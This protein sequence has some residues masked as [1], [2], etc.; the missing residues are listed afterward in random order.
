MKRA[1]MPAAFL[2]ALLSG[3]A[4]A[5]LRGQGAALV[6]DINVSGESGFSASM[7]HDFLTVGSRIFFLA[8]SP[9]QGGFLPQVAATDGTPTGTE[10]LGAPCTDPSCGSKATF[11]AASAASAASATGGTGETLFFT[12]EVDFF[13][14][15][16][17]RSDGTR[18]G[19][20]PLT[21]PGLELD[22]AGDQP[23]AYARVGKQLFFGACAGEQCGLYKSDG[24]VAGTGLVAALGAVPLSL[25]SLGE[26]LFFFA[27]AS[28]GLLALFVSD[29]TAAGTHSLAS[30]PSSLLGGLTAATGRVFFFGGDLGAT[31]GEELWTSDGTAAGT[32]AV[33]SFEAPNP[34]DFAQ[35]FQAV[36]G[37]LYFV[38]DDVTHGPEIWTSDGT[39]AGTRRVTEFGY[40]QPFPNPVQMGALGQRLLFLAT[41]GIHPTQLWSTTGTPESTAPVASI[42]ASG[43]LL[44][45]AGPSHLL[46]IGF[47]DPQGAGQVWTTDGTAGGTRPLLP[48]CPGSACGN[49]GAGPFALGGAAFLVQN[50]AAGK[51]FLW[52]TDG[53]ASGT[54]RW[55]DETVHPF[56]SPFATVPGLAV[57]GGRVFYSGMDTAAVDTVDNEELWSSDGRSGGTHLVADLFRQAPGSAPA[58]LTAVGG[59][60]FFTATD[61][62]T[63]GL[64]RSAGTADSTQPLAG[65]AQTLTAASGLL[66]F[67]QNGTDGMLRLWR[68]DGTAAGTRELPASDGARL[69]D[70]VSVAYR[71]QLAF[72]QQRNGGVEIWQSDGTDSGTGLLLALPAAVA[73]I[74]DLTAFDNELYFVADDAQ[75]QRTVW[76]SD[77]TAAGTRQV[78]QSIGY[79]VD[80]HFVRL[81]PWV[82]FVGFD[83]QDRFLLWRTDGTPGGTTAVYTGFFF[84]TL[85][86]TDPVVFGGTLYF[87]APTSAT[88]RGIF[89]SDGTEA[90]TTLV[91]ELGAEEDEPPS[92]P[93]TYPPAEFTVVGDLLF[94]VGDDGVH[95]RELWR[96]DGTT[97]GTVLVR[98]LFP[99]FLPSSPIGLT[100]AAGRLY[101]SADD[102]VHGREL[103]QSDGTADGTRLVED[104]APGAESS[105]PSG[106]TT[107]TDRLYWSADDGLHGRELWSLPLSGP[108]GCQPGDTRLCLA[109]NRFQVEIAWRDFQGNTGVGHA[110]PLT[111]DT[112]YFWFFASTNVETVVKVLDARALNQAFWVFYGALSNVEYT[113]T[114]TDTQTGLTRRYFNPAGQLASVGDT[115]GFGPLG[116]YARETPAAPASDF[117]LAST[118]VSARTDAR[119]ATGVCA[120]G[121]KR[122]CLQGGRFAVIAAWTDFQGKTGTGTAVPLT[123]DTGYFWFFDPTNVEVMTK[124]LDGRAVT[125]KFWF[126]YGALSNV[127]YTLTVTDTQTGTVKIYKNPSGQFG[128]VA[129]TGAF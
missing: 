118:L 108:T 49:V 39:P 116:S 95:G 37:R 89:R 12:T 10:F 105:S 111:A 66:F 34:F 126:F 53:T 47:D 85:D 64:W 100:A 104:V 125:G 92:S 124:V 40:D 93:G 79:R 54:R 88:Q 117:S 4:S 82:F 61:G 9:S 128:S 78:S 45:P 1:L 46:F 74:E 62:V 83:D 127:A 101:F 23:G 30:S 96:S 87:L 90:G 60:V 41:D 86:V 97:A 13:N 15:L 50:D 42:T 44:V 99:G 28:D 84:D 122:L 119:A 73:G 115:A 129:D 48:G 77:G 63:T 98:D 26:Q 69:V 32:R 11:I 94:F 17:W 106:I 110:V 56:L 103:W 67:T 6:R 121:P 102:G 5:P 36:G 57:L 55:S 14:H 35:P 58:N 52:R 68:T 21:T 8:D 107:T 22:P 113:M 51:P 76:R 81:A 109:A 114:V 24:T 38:A 112:G 71:G 7:P 120:P 20:F 3:L 18:A 16:L 27:R 2:L 33:T 59:E 29:G 25:T 31:Q 65:A 91:L 75:Q 80:P 43:S 19:T 123:P 72:A 70:G